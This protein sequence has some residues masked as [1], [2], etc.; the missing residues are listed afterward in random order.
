[1][2]VRRVDHGRYQQQRL[3]KRPHEQ[4][5][6]LSSPVFRATRDATPESSCSRAAVACSV[7]SPRSRRG[8]TYGLQG[9]RRR[10]F[11]S[12]GGRP[13]LQDRPARAARCGQ[14]MTNRQVTTPTSLGSPRREQDLMRTPGRVRGRR[15]NRQAVW[16][17]PACA[18]HAGR[19][20]C[21]AT[22]RRCSRGRP[23]PSRSPR[24]RATWTARSS[25]GGATSG[26]TP[27]SFALGRPAR[28][29]PRRHRGSTGPSSEP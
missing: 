19:P 18:P 25:S 4:L 2:T 17:G 10:G 21:R 6:A 12:R 11:G 24:R 20:P 13:V 14:G 3:T 26:H 7:C 16:P 5:Q 29:A 9:R 27:R 22:I 28:V 8:S 23:C 15:E 1:M